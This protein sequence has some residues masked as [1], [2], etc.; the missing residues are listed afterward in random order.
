[1]AKAF[2]FSLDA[3]V[4]FTLI[5]VVLHALIFLAAVPSSYYT[6]LMQ[7]NY[8]ARDSL[9]SLASADASKVLCDY[10]DQECLTFYSG[11]TLLDYVVSNKDDPDVIRARV[12][13]LIPNQ[14]GYRL[15]LLSSDGVVSLIY[16]TNKFSN[17]PHNKFYHKLKASAHSIYFGYTD[18]G[19]RG[20]DNPYCYMTCNPA[21]YPDCPN[22][23]DAPKSRYQIGDAAL[24]LIRLTV[25]R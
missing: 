11:K 19:R 3:F 22:V 25:Y 4:A 13:A 10:A 14:F 1:M 15:E 9:N 24:G 6:G 18:E 20:L 7:V 2:I 5:L 17:D 23:C 16:D 8:L 21:K 12:G